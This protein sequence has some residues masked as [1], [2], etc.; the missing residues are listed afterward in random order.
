MSQMKPRITTSTSSRGNPV[1]W[2]ECAARVAQDGVQLLDFDPSVL[3]HVRG[4]QL[5][6]SAR[7]VIAYEERADN[8]TGGPM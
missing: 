8:D 5:T 7:M 3:A 6:L 4:V 1:V 2:E